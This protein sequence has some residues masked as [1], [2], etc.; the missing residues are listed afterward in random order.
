MQNLYWPR[1]QNKKSGKIINRRRKMR[2]EKIRKFYNRDNIS[3]ATAGKKET[4]T[5][6]KEKIQRIYLLDTI[7][8]LHKKYEDN[9]GKTSYSSFLRH[10][11]FYV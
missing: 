8:N 2:I 6:Y 5:K 9:G 10:R 4:K 7:K 11:P 3:R 1:R